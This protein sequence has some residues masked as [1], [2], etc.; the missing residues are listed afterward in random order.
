MRKS[1]ISNRWVWIIFVIVWVKK[2]ETTWALTNS[3]RGGGIIVKVPFIDPW[4]FAQLG[5][6]STSLAERN[7][8]AGF[9]ISSFLDS[10]KYITLLR[11]ILQPTETCFFWLI[12]I[13]SAM[14]WILTVMVWYHSSSSQVCGTCMVIGLTRKAHKIFLLRSV[15]YCVEF[16]STL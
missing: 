12:R 2:N 3:C 7:M 5:L 16:A 10:S 9:S 6:K 15:L 14:R 8:R 4:P 11:A 13:L 1:D